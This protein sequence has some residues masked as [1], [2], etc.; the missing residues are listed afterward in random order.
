M[1]YS[2]LYFIIEYK[3][4]MSFLDIQEYVTDTNQNQDSINIKLVGQVSYSQP[5]VMIESSDF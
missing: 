3:I 5:N 2:V 1:M 4:L